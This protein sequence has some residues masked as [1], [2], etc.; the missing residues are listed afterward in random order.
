MKRWSAALAFA[1]ALVPG[2]AQAEL[3]EVRQVIFGMD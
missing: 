1:V 2:A 3:R